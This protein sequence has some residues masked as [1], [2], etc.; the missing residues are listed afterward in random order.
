MGHFGVGGRCEEADDEKRGVVSGCAI[1]FGKGVSVCG[2]TTIEDGE[3]DPITLGPAH[4]VCQTSL[5][6]SCLSFSMVYVVVVLHSC[7]T[8][9]G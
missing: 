7:C 5:A 4:K 3:S 6:M 1:N 9:A 2:Y 8:S